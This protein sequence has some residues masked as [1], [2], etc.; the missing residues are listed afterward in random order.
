M[1]IDQQLPKDPG[2]AAEILAAL[3]TKDEDET[4][5][6]YPTCQNGRQVTT[7]SGRPSAYCDNPDHTPV[8]NHRARAALKTTAT[9]GTSTPASKQEV[10][11]SGGVAPVES[12]RASVVGRIT[13]LQSDMERYVS[14]LMELSDPDLSAAQIQATLDRAETRIA[15]A[16]QNASTERSLRL[17][18]DMARTAAQEE[19]RAERE[20]ADQAIDRMEEAEARSQR[21]MEEATQHIANIQAERD[22]TIEQMRSELEQARENIGTQAKEAIALAQAAMVAAQEQTR[23]AESRAYDAEAAARAQTST[24]EQLVREAHETVKRERTEIDR[25][26]SELDFARTQVEQANVRAEAERTAARE[27]LERERA[28]VDRLRSELSTTRARADHFATFSDELR[29]QLLQIQTQTS[30]RENSAS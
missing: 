21:Q 4:I 30:Q 15:E 8:A 12:L 20:A 9:G 2:V 27:T 26:R 17:A 5:C 18:A 10:L 24:A 11:V 22:A 7:G 25:L 3:K 28:E 23:Q 29:T 1:G 13:Q 6:R 16:Q 19:A 14:T